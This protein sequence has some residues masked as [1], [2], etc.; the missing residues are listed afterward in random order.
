M[1]SPCHL[2]RGAAL[3]LPTVAGSLD[4]LPGFD[5]KV[6]PLLLLVPS[7]Q[8]IGVHPGFLKAN[9]QRCLLLWF[10]T[11]GMIMTAATMYGVP[12]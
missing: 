3:L 1:V 11:A 10:F 5:S 2:C 4:P 9:P 12:A 6:D 7:I 8:A